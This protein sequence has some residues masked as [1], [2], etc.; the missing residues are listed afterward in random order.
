MTYFVTDS[1]LNASLENI[2]YNAQEMILIVSPYIKLHGRIRDILAQKKGKP[3][4]KVKI[5]FGKNEKD[6]TKS[7][8]KEDIEFFLDFPDIEIRHNER[9]HAKFYAN[10]SQSLLTSLNLYE[11]S[12]NNNIEAGVLSEYSMANRALNMV[13]GGSRLD[14]ESTGYFLEIFEI[15]QLLYQKKANFKDKMLGFS[16]SYVGSSVEV[17]ELS[18]LF[19]VK[20]SSYAKN[21]AV[22]KVNE[23]PR[24][25]VTNQQPKVVEGYCIRTGVIIPFNPKK[26]MSDEAFKSWNRFGNSDYPEKYCH[27]SGEPSNGETSVNKPIL[28]KNWEKSKKLTP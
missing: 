13:G 21:T 25:Y 8:A 1:T 2:F 16:S 18:R 26:P 10:E 6:F 23:P 28:R 24:Q 7:F 4:I 11:Y 17:D 15:S 9:L 12:L 5:L 3:E 20:K 22:N 19:D 27:Y 14:G